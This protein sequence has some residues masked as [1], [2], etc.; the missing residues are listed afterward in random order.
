M[1]QITLD[2]CGQ[3]DG[4]RGDSAASRGDDGAGADRSTGR[5]ADACGPRHG[6]ASV[7]R[8]AVELAG[9]RRRACRVDRKRGRAA[10][11]RCASKPRR[12]AAVPVRSRSIG[13]WTNPWRTPEASS[14]SETAFVVILFALVARD[15]RRRQ[16]PGAKEP[17]RRTRRSTRRAGAGQCRG[18]GAVGALGVPGAR[19]AVDRPARESSWSA[20]RPRC[21]TRRCSGRC[22]SR[23]SRSSGATGRRRWCRGRRS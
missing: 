1:T 7:R 6:A 22:I 2:H 20:L 12:F 8:T 10:I 19:D 13:P 18:G 14:G 23:S 5:A 3:D 21:S 16:R 9:R 15:H 4:F 11:D 17:S